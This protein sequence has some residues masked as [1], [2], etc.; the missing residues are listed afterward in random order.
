MSLTVYDTLPE[1]SLKIFGQPPG[2]FIISRYLDKPLN[3]VCFLLQVINSYQPGLEIS[4]SKY[5]LIIF[6][7]VVMVSQRMILIQILIKP[8]ILNPQQNLGF[9]MLVKVD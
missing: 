3:G 9:A 6:P 7:Q 1:L 2:I 5:S 8:P 4:C